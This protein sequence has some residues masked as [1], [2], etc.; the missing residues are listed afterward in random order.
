MRIKDKFVIVNYACAI[1]VI[2]VLWELPVDMNISIHTH[3]C[4]YGVC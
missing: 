3:N 4:I 2:L 1:I